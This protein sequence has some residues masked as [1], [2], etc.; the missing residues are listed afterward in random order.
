MPQEVISGNSRQ[1]C[2]DFTWLTEYRWGVFSYLVG[3]EN[4]VM[5]EWYAFSFGLFG[6]S[7]YNHIRMCFDH[8]K[9]P[10]GRGC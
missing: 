5:Y 9:Q 4:G 2:Y 3:C 10:N 8:Q 1:W 6:S 7:S